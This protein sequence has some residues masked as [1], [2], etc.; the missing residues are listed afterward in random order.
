[1]D[2]RDIESQLTAY[3]DGELSESDAANIAEYLNDHPDGRSFVETYQTLRRTLSTKAD[4]H[5]APSYLKHRVLDGITLTPTGLRGSIR[6][7]L[8]A[9]RLGPV[10]SFALI[11]VTVIAIVS[12]VGSIGV[13]ADAS[14]VQNS[15]VITGEIQCIDCAVAHQWGVSSECKKYGHRNGIVTADGT[16]WTVKHSDQWA[17]FVHD[18][19]IWGTSVTV[20]G[21]QCSAAHYV[22]IRTVEFD[23]P[24]IARITHEAAFAE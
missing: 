9:F 17:P 18:T 16:M 19:S 1:M 4:P 11:A 7:W 5:L 2:M 8:R 22:D 13:K 24:T 20:N 23:S 15:V 12:A 10:P 6:E 14:T 21:H 3:A